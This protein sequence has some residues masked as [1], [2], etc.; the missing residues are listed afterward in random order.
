M[1]SVRPHLCKPRDHRLLGEIWQRHEVTTQTANTIEGCALCVDNKPGRGSGSPVSGAS[2][3]GWDTARGLFCAGDVS[4]IPS[5]PESSGALLCAFPPRCQAVTS[6]SAHRTQPLISFQASQPPGSPQ[7]RH[8]L[9]PSHLCWNL[10]PLPLLASS[11]PCQP[12]L[13]VLRSACT[14]CT[15]ASPSCPV[16]AAAD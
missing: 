15:P 5:S 1:L 8:R 12:G 3:E 7:R 10:G 9:F 13:V 11:I 16:T 14:P 2:G 6:D 4:D